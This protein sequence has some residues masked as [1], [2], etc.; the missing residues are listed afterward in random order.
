MLRAALISKNMTTN[1]P[2][3]RS[4]AGNVNTSPVLDAL[5]HPNYRENIASLN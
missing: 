2:L 4:A 5:G 1:Q 3:G